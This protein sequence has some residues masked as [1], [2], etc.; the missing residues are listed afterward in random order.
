MPEFSRVQ[1]AR[2]LR[3][4]RQ[5]NHQVYA[6]GVKFAIPGHDICESESSAWLVYFPFVSRS[7]TASIFGKR[8]VF[9]HVMAVISQVDSRP[10]PAQAFRGSN[11]RSARC[12]GGKPLFL[13]WLPNCAVLCQFQYQGPGFWS[14]S[15]VSS[16]GHRACPFGHIHTSACH[17]K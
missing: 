13:D 3:Q 1:I 10:S 4:N 7:L 5:L 15:I 6:D 2:S 14:P 8:C 17:N 9:S 16:S 12:M 11:L